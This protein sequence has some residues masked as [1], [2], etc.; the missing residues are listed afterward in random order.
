MCKP[1]SA[2]HGVHAASEVLA[3][4][5]LLQETI[6]RPESCREA[7]LE[8]R[9]ELREAGE[10]RRVQWIHREKNGL[11]DARRSIQNSA[12]RLAREAVLFHLPVQGCHTDAQK[13]CGLS[14]VTGDQVQRV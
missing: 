13:I 11:A 6:R 4:L 14:L 10:V 12:A 9:I 5:L 1:H 7:D 3:N 2:S 8:A